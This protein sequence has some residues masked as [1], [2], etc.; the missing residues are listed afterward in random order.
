M[1]VKEIPFFQYFYVW[2][3]R[4]YWEKL[5][6]EPFSH[7]LTAEVLEICVA[8]GVDL[9]AGMAGAFAWEGLQKETA[10]VFYEEDWRRPSW[11]A[12]LVEIGNVK[13]KRRNCFLTKM[14][15]TASSASQEICS[16]C[17]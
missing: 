7:D 13:R 17:A 11:V 9:E 15:T 1:L 10:C 12:F 8:L 6:L 2:V 5:S 16:F 14:L 3:L 4:F